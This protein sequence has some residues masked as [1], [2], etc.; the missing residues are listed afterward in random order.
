[1]ALDAE[2]KR[3]LNDYAMLARADFEKKWTRM[4]AP[5][6]ARWWNEWCTNDKTNHDRLGWILMHHTGVRPWKGKPNDKP[7]LFKELD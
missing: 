7:Y 3:R 6:V 4:D 2:T 1:M 5:A